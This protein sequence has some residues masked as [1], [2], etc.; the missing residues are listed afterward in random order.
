VFQDAILPTTAY[1]GG[2]AE[3]A[4]F[5]QS[6]VLYEQV[7][8]RVTPILPRLSATLIEPA[9][10][11]VMAQHEVSLPEAMTT[12]EELAQRLGARGGWARGRCRLRRSASWQRR[13]MLWMRR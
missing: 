1:V 7:L 10:G 2:P 8:G 9:I 13:A 12:A 11:A 4:Y 3:V 5:A 6:A